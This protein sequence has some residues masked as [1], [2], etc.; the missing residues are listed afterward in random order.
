MTEKREK[1]LRILQ[2]HFP[3]TGRPFLELAGRAGLEEDDLLGSV[4]S[5]L[6]EKTIR[7]FGPVFEPGM[8]GYTGTLVA[9]EVS[10][11]RVEELAGYMAGTAEIT[12]NY[13]RDNELNLWF[14]ITARSVS[15]IGE[16]IGYVSRFPGVRRL[17]DLPA[18][19]VFKIRAVFGTKGETAARPGPPPVPAATLNAMERK[20]VRAVQEDFP[21]VPEPFAEISARTGIPE[22]EVIRTVGKWVEDGTIRRFGARLD[23]RRSGYTSNVLA[24]WRGND[25]D[26]WGRKFAELPDVSHCYRRKSHAEWPYE[27]YTMVHASSEKDMD[28][29]VGVMTAVTGGEEPLLLKTRRELKK[30]SMKY[31][32]ED[33]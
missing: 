14:T 2:S 25:V 30:T 20:L 12:H 18:V 3:I 16:I 26:E 15:R 7:A 31:F 33:T 19:T 28:R 10:P 5:L 29:V 27:L 13:L 23:P 6:D 24:V 9:V 1:L 17:Y 4:R 22:S 32:L 8:L 11:D 21:I